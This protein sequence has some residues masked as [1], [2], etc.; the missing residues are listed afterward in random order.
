MG[1]WGVRMGGGVLRAKSSLAVRPGFVSLRSG[2]VYSASGFLNA[3]GAFLVVSTSKS[4]RS[5]GMC[6]VG[7]IL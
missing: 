3:E 5:S 2:T 7:E 1:E 6:L 4:L